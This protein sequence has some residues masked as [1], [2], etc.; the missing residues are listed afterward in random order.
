MLSIYCDFFFKKEEISCM[1]WKFS[2]I[3]LSFWE[4]KMNTLWALLVYCLNCPSIFLYTLRH[5]KRTLIYECLGWTLYFISFIRLRN[6]SWEFLSLVECSLCDELL[7][8][9]WIVE[10]SLGGEP[11]N[12]SSRGRMIWKLGESL[13]V[14]NQC[15]SRGS[16]NI[17]R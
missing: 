14:E 11:I 5:I 15:T 8:I 9:L 7:C 3:K 10:C 2:Y 16:H 4:K 12:H 17:N 6:V 1:V 13:N